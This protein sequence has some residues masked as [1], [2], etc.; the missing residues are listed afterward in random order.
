MLEARELA[1]ESRELCARALGFHAWCVVGV[2]LW[3]VKGGRI[4]V[5]FHS[6]SLARQAARRTGG[7]ASKVAAHSRAPHPLIRSYILLIGASVVSRGPLPHR[8]IPLGGASSI[9][10]KTLTYIAASLV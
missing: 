9:Q 3:S 6:S 8:I 5:T 2:L 4:V 1:P 7:R 10:C